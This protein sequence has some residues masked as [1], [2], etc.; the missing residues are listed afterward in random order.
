MKFFSLIQRKEKRWHILSCSSLFVGKR[1]TGLGRPVVL[2][3]G[4]ISAAFQP[5]MVCKR[6][7]FS[8]FSGGKVRESMFPARSE[9]VAASPRFSMF[10][11]ICWKSRPPLLLSSGGLFLSGSV[12]S[13]DHH[14]AGL[15]FLLRSSVP[16]T[17]PSLASSC[18]RS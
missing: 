16:R 5:G 8:T 7:A 6:A 15:L 2:C 9:V 18:Q 4:T 13:R 11:L 12:F 3:P 10:Y 14:L 17:L 1:K